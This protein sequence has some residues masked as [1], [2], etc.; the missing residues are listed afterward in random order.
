[1]RWVPRAEFEQ[2]IPLIL[3]A[4]D[5]PSIDGVNTWFASKAAAERGYKVVLSGVGGDEL[6]CGYSSFRR[7][8]MAAAVG[9]TVKFIPG[10]AA[11]LRTSLVKLAKRRSKPKLAAV[12]DMMGSF[13]GVYFLSRGLFL[14]D[15]LPALMGEE[16]AH[17]GLTRLGTTGLGITAVEARDGQASV[18][19]LESTFYLR[20]QLLRDSDWASMAHSLELRTPFVDAFLLQNLG[21]YISLFAK[22]A[23]KTM[24]AESPR[25]PL[26][27]EI[28]SR[29][30][31]GFSIPMAEWLTSLDS[32]RINSSSPLRSPKQEPW[33]RRW[34]Q[35]VIEA[36]W[37]MVR[38][39]TSPP[40]SATFQ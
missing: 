32:E 6:F 2:D 22:G 37:G 23:G 10:G 30:K 24:L 16:A 13:E 26:P 19:S 4:M 8:P 3:D 18:G 28:I 14:P 25:K 9:R 17:E 29:H 7:I 12:P 20:N 35:T 39:A 15:E 21:C 34:A 38:K 27:H 5:Q 40:R 33:A 11:L 36:D 1:V 31:T